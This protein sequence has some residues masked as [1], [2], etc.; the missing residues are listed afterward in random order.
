MR[1][2]TSFAIASLCSLPALAQQQ[3]NLAQQQPN[4]AQQQPT[5]T[6]VAAPKIV[7]VDTSR[8]HPAP[9]RIIRVPPA[10][11]QA[12]AGA[13]EGT[14]PRYDWTYYANGGPARARRAYAIWRMRFGTRYYPATRIYGPGYGVHRYHAVRSSSNRVHFR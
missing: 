9:V 11:A 2:I 13:Y 1:W 4:V 8:P 14:R 10:P 12:P 7:V 6:A 3:R 5:S